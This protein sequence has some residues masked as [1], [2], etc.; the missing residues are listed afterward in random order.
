MIRHFII[1]SI[2][3]SLGLNG[4]GQENAKKHN[5]DALSEITTLLNCP[6]DWS[7]KLTL[8]NDFF[9]SFYSKNQVGL[10]TFTNG[11]RF[12]ELMV[13]NIEVLKDSIFKYIKEQENAKSSCRNYN[14]NEPYMITSFETNNFLIIPRLCPNCDF[15]DDKKCKRLAKEISN[16]TQKL[17][18]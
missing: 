15:N 17:I 9:D 7:M 11:N 8:T 4:F 13:Y 2:F 6:R 10:I 12:I 14:T 3:L 5:E 1:I 18:K 16:W